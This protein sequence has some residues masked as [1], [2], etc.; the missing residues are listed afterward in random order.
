MR[1]TL[2]QTG[3]DIFASFRP[4]FH[5]GT[6]FGQRAP[7]TKA[8]ARL[9]IYGANL[10]AGALYRLGSH[11]YSRYRKGTSLQVLHKARNKSLPDTVLKL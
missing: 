7:A 8:E 2:R 10:D 1:N 6:D 3:K 4:H 9:A 11:G 5:P